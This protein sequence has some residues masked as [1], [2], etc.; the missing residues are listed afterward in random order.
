MS[1]SNMDAKEQ[2]L[3]AI[4]NYTAVMSKYIYYNVNDFNPEELPVQDLKDTYFIPV[5]NGGLP[6]GKLIAVTDRNMKIELY[7]QIKNGLIKVHKAEGKTVGTETISHKVSA[8]KRKM[9]RC[10]QSRRKPG[11]SKVKSRKRTC[12]V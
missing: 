1:I 3:D 4:D 10:V 11:T 9:G 5:H 6:K 8:G 7:R 2:I 12:K